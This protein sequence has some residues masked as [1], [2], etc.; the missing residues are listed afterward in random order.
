MLTIL[1]KRA[2]APTCA[3]LS[4]S[5][6]ALADGHLQDVLRNLPAWLVSV[7]ILLGGLATL[8]ITLILINWRLNIL[9]RNKTTELKKTNSKLERFLDIVDRRVVSTR[10]DISGKIIYVSKKHKDISGYTNE[11]VVGK[12]ITHLTHPSTD[13]EKMQHIMQ[14]LQR[15]LSWEGEMMNIDKNGET[16][17]THTVASPVFDENENIIEYATISEDI[18]DKKR[19]SKLLITDQLTGIYNRVKLDELLELEWLRFKRGGNPY[20]LLLIDIDHFK[21]VNDKLGHLAGDSILR[22]VAQTLLSRIRKNDI[23]G[24]WG[25]EEFLV[26]CPETNLQGAI[27]LA[28]TLRQSI[29][30]SP[31]NSST[32]LTVSIGISV[33]TPK[34][35]SLESLFGEADNAMYKAKKAGRNKVLAFT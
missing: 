8:S 28:E 19:I 21:Q 16:Y 13:P 5:H 17:W 9:V 33:C 25:G 7:L 26:W 30:R 27:Q 20:S 2:A 11:D 18:T 35:T 10:T 4:L 34:T 31:I 22:Q 23:V 32:H 1:P 29:E 15:G 3:F 6:N 14:R 24:R 12:F